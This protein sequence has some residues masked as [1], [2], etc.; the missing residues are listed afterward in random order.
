LGMRSWPNL[1]ACAVGPT[2]AH[3]HLLKRLRMRSWPN[4][5]ACAVGPTFAHVRLAQ[6]L[7]MR[8][9]SNFCAYAVGPTF[10]HAQLT[11]LL[12]MRSWLNFCSCALES[13]RM[14]LPRCLCVIVQNLRACALTH[15]DGITFCAFVLI[16]FCAFVLA[17]PIAHAQWTYLLFMRTR[18]DFSHILSVP[19]FYAS[20]FDLPFARKH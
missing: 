8:T 4:C 5:C 13:F 16:Q 11:Q 10:A 7:R 2:F 9:C 6:P 14:K 19:I 1:C 15:P 20:A 3:G 12:R 18:P 17:P